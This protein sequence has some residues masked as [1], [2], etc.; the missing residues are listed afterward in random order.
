VKK[1]TWISAIILILALALVGAAYR[2]LFAGV[3][4]STEEGSALWST[5]RAY[6]ATLVQDYC[7]NALGGDAVFW[8]LR[9]DKPEPTV[10]GGWFMVWE[11]E[12]DKSFAAD[13]PA[14]RWDGARVLKVGVS[15]DRLHGELTSHIG[16]L[17]VVRTFSPAADVRRGG[18]AGS[19][20][21][22]RRAPATG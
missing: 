2:A 12:N 16:D 4:C 5:D 20:P 13:P 22:A 11:I 15:T 6:K 9:V 14:V 17:I 18:A 8:K 1:A 19:V 21:A 3:G 10:S 7:S